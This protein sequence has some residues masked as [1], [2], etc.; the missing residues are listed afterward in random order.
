M[1]DSVGDIISNAIKST[2]TW[3]FTVIDS[4]TGSWSFIIGFIVISFTASL[5]VTFVGARV[6][7]GASDKAKEQKKA[8]AKENKSKK[9]G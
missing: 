6:R 4:I 9:G 2:I 8:K 7:A 1:L 3:F 5:L